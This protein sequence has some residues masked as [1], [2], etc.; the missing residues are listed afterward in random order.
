MHRTIV[1]S[2]AFR[3]AELKSE[4][5]RIVGLLLLLA[6]LLLWTVL[7]SLAIGHLRL[8]VAQ[9]SLTI[10]AMVYEVLMLRAVQRALARKGRI[11]LTVSVINAFVEAQ[12]QGAR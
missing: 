11:S 9:L 4:S 2:E 12:I 8:L 7:R 3:Q 6:A 10:V 1:E 5:Y